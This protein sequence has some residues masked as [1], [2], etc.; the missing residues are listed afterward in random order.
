[1]HGSHQCQ[2]PRGCDTV[3]VGELGN[4]AVELVRSLLDFMYQAHASSMTTDDLVELEHALANEA[5]YDVPLRPFN[6]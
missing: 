5:A 3:V 6:T 4:D 1:M 2:E